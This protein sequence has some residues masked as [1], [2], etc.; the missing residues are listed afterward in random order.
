MPITAEREEDLWSFRERLESMR[1]WSESR[2]A[3]EPVAHLFSRIDITGTRPL[4]QAHD[5]TKGV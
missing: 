2:E 1:K 3:R 5:F 4:L